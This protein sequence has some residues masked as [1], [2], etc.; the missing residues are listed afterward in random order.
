MHILFYTGMILI[1]GLIMGKLVSYIKLPEV[2]GYLLAGVLI[3]P[4]ILGIVPVEAAEKLNVISEMALGLIA[5]SIGSEFNFSHMKKIGK[6]ILLITVL[7]SLS[8]VILVDLAMIFIF[9]EKLFFSISLGAIAAATA[10]AATL[11]VIRQYKAK[12]PLVNTLLPIVA[13][14]DAVG[15]IIFGISMAITKSL[16]S[17]DVKLPMGKMILL[18]FG[19]IFLAFVVGICIGIILSIVANRANGEDQLLTIALAVIFAAIGLSVEL[20]IS[21]LLVCMC[22]GATVTNVVPNNKRLLSIVDRFTPPVFAVFFTLAGIELNIS[23]LKDVGIIGIAYMLLRVL[24]KM[25]GA[26]LGAKIINSPKTVQKY[27]GFTLIPQAGVAIGLAMIAETEL[28]SPYGAKI[29]TI[30]LSATVIYELIGPLMTKI[31]VFRAGEVPLSNS[32]KSN[33]NC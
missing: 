12:G 33:I 8:A 19:E 7:E 23:I 4:S 25:L 3:G 2:T 14:D 29:R 6:G 13:M 18:P 16:V 11:M 31:A 10:P 30:I 27:L 15:I 21:A 9:K 28:P 17:V 24:G 1:S 32:P 20:N 22:I 5:Y 26:S